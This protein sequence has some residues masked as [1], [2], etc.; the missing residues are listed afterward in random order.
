M[1][2]MKSIR[3]SCS[4]YS[5]FRNRYHFF[6]LNLLFSMREFQ[7]MLYIPL[8]IHYFLTVCVRPFYHQYTSLVS[9]M[10]LLEDNKCN[11]QISESQAESQFTQL[12]EAAKE[13]FGVF[14]LLFSA[15]L[16]ILS[17][18]SIMC[19]CQQYRGLKMLINFRLL[20]QTALSAILGKHDQVSSWKGATVAV[21][22]F[23]SAT[24]FQTSSVLPELIE[25]F[26]VYFSNYCFCMSLASSRKDIFIVVVLPGLLH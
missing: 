21:G 7:S 18:W 13:V 14:G 11:N 4:N 20:N 15:H 16:V 8:A 22:P 1:I 19:L 25:N 23:I 10:K 3:F 24:S 9:Q 5:S 6:M 17:F 2:W 26:E 12:K